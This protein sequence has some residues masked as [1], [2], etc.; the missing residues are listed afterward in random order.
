MKEKNFWPLGIMS[1]LIGGMGIVVA[2]VVF[3]LK[4]SPKNDLVYFKSHNEVDLNFNAMFKTYEN[5]KASYYFLVDLKPL[6]ASSKTPILPYFSKGTHGDKQLQEK[7]L[8][9]ALILSKSNTLYIE[10]QQIEPNLGL[11]ELQVYLATYPS[12]AP[13]R[14]LSTVVCEHACKPLVG[15]D[16]LESDKLGRYK[17]LFKLIFKNKEELILEQLALFKS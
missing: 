14:L 12:K 9:N 4:H 16:L 11:K 8:Q 15:F 17:I 10:L 13:P 1:V 7:M 5:F 6:T 3:A 2:L